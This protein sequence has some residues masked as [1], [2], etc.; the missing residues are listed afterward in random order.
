[1]NAFLKNKLKLAKEFAVHSQ[2]DATGSKSPASCN[3]GRTEAHPVSPKPPKLP[4]PPK[5]F[6]DVVML[7]MAG[8]LMPEGGGGGGGWDKEAS[9]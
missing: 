5:S 9:T 4:K 1:M 8:S 3:A 6:F 2:L 7:W